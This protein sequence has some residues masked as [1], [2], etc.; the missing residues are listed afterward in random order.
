MN[1]NLIY[2]FLCLR[3]FVASAVSKCKCGNTDVITKFFRK[4]R[5]C[6]ASLSNKTE[7]AENVLSWI[8][9]DKSWVAR[10]LLLRLFFHAKVSTDKMILVVEYRV[11]LHTENYCLHDWFIQYLKPVVVRKPYLISLRYRLVHLVWEQRLAKHSSADWGR[12]AALLVDTLTV[13]AMSEG[14]DLPLSCVQEPHNW[15]T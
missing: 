13:P 2:S 5:N 12:L 14:R 9:G 7:Y 10:S 6:K 8:R 15:S 4:F 3:S 11:P 1:D